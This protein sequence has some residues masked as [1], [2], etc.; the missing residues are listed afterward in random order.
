M[1]NRRALIILILGSSIAGLAIDSLVPGVLLSLVAL[2]TIVLL[3]SLHII[4]YAYL[5]LKIRRLG[6][7]GPRVGQRDRWQPFVNILIPAKNEGRVIEGCLRNIF[8][9]DYPDFDVWLIDDGST[10][11]TL[12][13]SQ[14]LQKEFK[15]LRV[16]NRSPEAKRGKSAALNEALKLCVGD[17]VAVFDADAFVEPD[18]LRVILPS[19]EPSFIAGVQAQKCIV[20]DKQNT[21]VLCQDAEYAFDSF[22]QAG[23]DL[24]GG[25]VEFR[26]NG[27]LVKRQALAEVGGWNEDSITD[28]LD[29]STRLLMHGWRLKFV[30]QATVFEEGISK[31]KPLMRQRK[32]WAE[33]SIRRYLDYVREFLLSGRI[34]LNQRLEVVA[35]L[36]EFAVPPLTISCILRSLGDN[37]L[38][39]STMPLLATISIVMAMSTWS[40]IFLGIRL[41]RPRLAVLDAIT[42]SIKANLYLYTLWV[43]CVFWSFFEIMRS[44]RA[45][46]WVATEHHG[47]AVEAK[48]A[49]D[50]QWSA[51]DRPIE[52]VL[53]RMR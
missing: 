32:R 27:Q 7:I 48:P 39:Y 4:S 29:L 9:L 16:L 3:G 50:A 49:C 5:Q 46:A 40:A 18:F 42:G 17:V 19:L 22:L 45:S 37:H 30:P 11:E 44:N 14:A 51:D 1:S 36:T 2:Y 25:A 24:L 43:P 47:T 28:D 31:V 6:A 52:A 15:D 35:F 53:T 21:L 8:R 23:R 20:T 10:D 33:G 41:Y 26:G 13:I 12:A 34:S 38:L